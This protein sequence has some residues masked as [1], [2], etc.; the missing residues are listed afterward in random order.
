MTKRWHNGKFRRHPY[1]GGLKLL[2]VIAFAGA[3]L[4]WLFAP[5]EAVELHNPLISITY[6]ESVKQEEPR[7]PVLPTP[8][9]IAVP[10]VRPTPKQAVKR[11]TET[12]NNDNEA[13]I[14]SVFTDNP[15]EAVH[16]AFC[17]SSLNEKAAHQHSSAKGLFQV[18][19][20]TWK[21]NKCSGDPLNADD[22]IACAKKIYDRQGWRPWLASKPCHGLK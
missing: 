1:T 18:I 5:V 12:H 21:S 3:Y 8:K 22:N 10:T 13:K 11:T 6:G 20:G 19:N 2:L 16:V 14:R 7:Q 9:P 17:E 4:Q 15:D